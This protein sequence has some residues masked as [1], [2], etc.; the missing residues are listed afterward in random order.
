MAAI[1]AYTLSDPY[2]SLRLVLRLCGATFLLTGFFFLLLPASS[3]TALMGLSGPLWPLRLAAAGLLTLGVAFLFAASER[4]IGLAVLVPCI[5]GNALPAL[6]L[7]IAYLQGEM[8]GFAWPV[9]GA[10]LI[11]FVIWLIGAVT[12]LRFL[13][14]EYQA[15]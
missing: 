14:S 3:A 7:V 5:L 10:M 15:D 4:T 11:L 13:R 6:L 8:S 9:Q 2:R 12:P 1:M